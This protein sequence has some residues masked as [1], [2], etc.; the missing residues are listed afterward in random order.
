MCATFPVLFAPTTACVLHT[1][2]LE[3]YWASCTGQGKATLNLQTHTN[4]NAPT[5]THAW[6]GTLHTAQHRPGPEGDLLC[7]GQLGKSDNP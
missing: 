5:H 1:A 4:T 3:P 2:A 6:T 7:S